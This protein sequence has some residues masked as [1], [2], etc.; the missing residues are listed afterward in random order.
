[1][2]T[3]LKNFFKCN[4]RIKNGLKYSIRKYRQILFIIMKKFFYRVQAGD[5]VL[6]LAQKFNLSVCKIIADNNLKKE[7]PEIKDQH[8]IYDPIG[9]NRTGRDLTIVISDL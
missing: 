6:S 7:I 5:S 1:M 2:A 4:L 9:I 3:V 8:T